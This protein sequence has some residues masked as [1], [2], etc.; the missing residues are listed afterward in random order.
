MENYSIK[1]SSLYEISREEIEAGIVSET[2]KMAFEE[3]KYDF[4]NLPTLKYAA[5]DKEA[6]ILIY[7][8]NWAISATVCQE[9]QGTLFPI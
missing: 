3:L 6:H 8:T 4:A 1:A 9:D 5:S 2:A 7:A